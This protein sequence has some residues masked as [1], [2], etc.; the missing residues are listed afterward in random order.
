LDDLMFKE[1]SYEKDMRSAEFAM[2]V[3]EFELDLAKAALV[4]IRPV[5]PGDPEPQRLDVRS[6]ITGRV[7]KVHQESDANVTPGQKLIELG[8]PGDLEMEIDVLSAD[9][10]KIKPGAKVIVEHWGG[11]YPLSGRVRLVEPSGFTKT[12]A[13]GVE[14][15]RVWVIVDFDDPPEKR[16]SLGDCYRV[17]VRIIIWEGKDVLKM[18]SGA[19]F[20]HENGWAVYVVED[21]QAVLRPVQIGRGNGLETQIV[22]GLRE[23]EQVI[24]HPSDKIKAGAAVV[25]R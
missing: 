11:E 25:P 9:A 16:P 23:G 13:L 21:G 12:S 20:R 18:P 1:K 4:R 14:E 19:L 10:V 15:Q 17:E 5:S 3:A 8:D 24:L 2:H 7:L 6:P 22:S